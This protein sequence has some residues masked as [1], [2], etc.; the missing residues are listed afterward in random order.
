M[1]S[2]ETTQILFNSPALHS[3]KRGQLIK[4]CK[5]HSVRAAGKNVELIQRL[6]DHAA[7]LPHGSPLSVATRSEQPGDD[8]DSKR[9]SEQWELLMEDIL[10]LPE[11]SSRQT[12]SSLRSVSGTA[13]DEFGTGGGSKCKSSIGHVSPFPVKF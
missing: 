10:E 5:I 6:K 9:P 13:P 7:S 2:S 12:L 11:G 1:S 8:K 4:L 3:L